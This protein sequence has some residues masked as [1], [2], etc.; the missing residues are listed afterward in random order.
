MPAG[1]LPALSGVSGN[2]SAALATA[3]GA[4]LLLLAIKFA[5]TRSDASA[6]RLFFGSLIYLPLVWIAMIADKL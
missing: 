1:L 3:L 5:A 4:A 6:R 2:V